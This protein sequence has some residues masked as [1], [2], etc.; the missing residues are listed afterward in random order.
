MIDIDK[1]IE[2]HRRDLRELGEF[3]A[4]RLLAERIAAVQAEAATRQG[5]AMKVTTD[6]MLEAMGN[7]REIPIAVAAVIAVARQGDMSPESR[8]ELLRGTAGIAALLREV[9][10]AVEKLVSDFKDEGPS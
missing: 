6:E 8:A 3:N 2:A 9:A 4:Y 10:A 7:L 1:L 5:R